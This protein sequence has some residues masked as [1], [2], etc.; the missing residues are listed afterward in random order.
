[1]RAMWL[2]MGEPPLQTSRNEANNSSGGVCL[3]RYPLAPAAS[4]LKIKS[5]F[6]YT[7]NMT[8]CVLGSNGFSSRTQST[9]FLPGRLMSIRITSGLVRGNSASAAS[10]VACALAHSKPSDSSI[11]FVRLPRRR[12][13]SSTMDTRMFIFAFIGNVGGIGQSA[14]RHFG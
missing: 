12:M 1:M 5:V 2:V 8:I 6:S 14:Y 3:S 13:L 4:A 10:A 11:S 9:P 7:V